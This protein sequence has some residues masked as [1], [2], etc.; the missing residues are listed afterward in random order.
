ME[1]KEWVISSVYARKDIDWT[2]L[3]FTVW[4]KEN[5][6]VVDWKEG[7]IYR[8]DFGPASFEKTFWFKDESRLNTLVWQHCYITRSL[9]LK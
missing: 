4:V 9:T 5:K 8:F 3:G 7:Y 1:K 6:V 2:V